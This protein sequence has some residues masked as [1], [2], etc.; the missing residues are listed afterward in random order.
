MA[1]FTFFRISKIFCFFSLRIKCRH[2]I[3]D[4]IPI[5]LS[6]SCGKCECFCVLCVCVCACV[7]V[8]RVC[9]C[10][11]VFLCTVCAHACTCKW[12]TFQKD[13]SGIHI[14]HPTTSTHT[15]Q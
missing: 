3:S 15:T 11:R 14:W 8:V 9:V 7:C 12:V 10:K 13:L 5:I 1:S 4:I 6:V 2:K